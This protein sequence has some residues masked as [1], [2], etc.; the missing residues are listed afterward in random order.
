MKRFYDA[1][2]PCW[3]RL[4]GREGTHKGKVVGNFVLTEQ[5]TIF[6]LIQMDDRE[7]PYIEV[8]DPTLMADAEG[9]TLPYEGVKAGASLLSSFKDTELDS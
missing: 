8:R 6:F 7:W 3:V 9:D 1:G 2:E 5:P 4:W